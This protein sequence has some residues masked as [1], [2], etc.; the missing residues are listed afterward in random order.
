MEPCS[1]DGFSLLHLSSLLNIAEDIGKLNRRVE[2]SVGTV[3]WLRASENRIKNNK[4]KGLNVVSMLVDW[5]AYGM[6]SVWIG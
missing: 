2:E 4:C 3:F 1:S 6:D 5:K